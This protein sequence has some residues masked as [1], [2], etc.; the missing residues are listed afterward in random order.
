MKERRKEE[1]E[2][3]N[4]ELLK[5]YLAE[6]HDAIYERA[7]YVIPYESKNWLDRI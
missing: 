6:K 2:R 5:L 3:R 4:K 7:I 1:E